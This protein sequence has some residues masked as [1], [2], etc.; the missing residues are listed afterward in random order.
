VNLRCVALHTAL[1]AL[2]SLLALCTCCGAAFHS[3]GTCF[4]IVEPQRAARHHSK[5]TRCKH[6]LQPPTANPR[7]Q[8]LHQTGR[9]NTATYH[10]IAPPASLCTLD[11]PCRCHRIERNNKHTMDV[12]HE[13]AAPEAHETTRR[14]PRIHIDSGRL[15]TDSMVTVPLSETD[16]VPAAEDEAVSPALQHPDIT[17]RPSSAEIMEAFGRRGSCDGDSSPAVVSPTTSLSDH[18][19]PKTQTS[20]ERSRTNSNGSDQS[21]HVDWAELEKKEEQEPQEEGQDEVSFRSRGGNMG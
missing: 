3:F 1:F 15:P 2:R 18:D 16:G 21:A 17:I 9:E 20:L 14:A 11:G 7:R 12:A 10:N 4:A 5:R 8:F 6:R 19:V 13:T